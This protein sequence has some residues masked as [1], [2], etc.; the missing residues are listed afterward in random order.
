MTSSDQG[1]GTALPF[2][3]GVSRLLLPKRDIA[4]AKQLI[5][6]PVRLG[7]ALANADVGAMAPDNG[8]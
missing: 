2:G 3:N 4:D 1:S 5:P 8:P 6:F 7:M